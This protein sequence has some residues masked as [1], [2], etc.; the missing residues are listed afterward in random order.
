MFKIIGMFVLTKRF[1]W[2]AEA[3]NGH[4]GCVS[5]SGDRC[6]ISMRICVMEFMAS[7]AITS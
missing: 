7:M 3:A 5:G 4:C 1:L 2:V 6:W